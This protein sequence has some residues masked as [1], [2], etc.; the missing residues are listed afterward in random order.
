MVSV[1]ASGFS[2]LDLSSGWG[3]CVVFLCETLLS[4]SLGG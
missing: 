1:H 2:N 3:H 4:H